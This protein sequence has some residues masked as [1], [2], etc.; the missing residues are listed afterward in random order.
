MKCIFRKFRNRAFAV[1]LALSSAFAQQT[2]VTIRVDASKPIGLLKHLND[3]D[4]GP[5]CEHGIIDLSGYYKQ[6]DVRNVRLHDAPW[7]YADVLDVDYIFPD[8]NADPDRPE[9]YRFAASDFYIAS[10]TRLNINLIYRIGYSAQGKSPTPHL[11]LPGSPEKWAD[12]AAH[13]VRHY[14][15][16][17]ANGPHA[18]IRSWEIWNEPDN[19]E[20]WSGTP[21][22]YFQLYE[23]TAKAVKAVDPSLRVGGPAIAGKLDFLEGF[24][25]YA[26]QRNLPVD[27]VS[28]HIYTQNPGDVVARAHKVREIA[29][30]LGFPH[31]ES[32]LDEWNYG[33]DDWGP[34]FKDAAATRKYFGDM[35]GAT[36]A[37]FDAAVLIALQDAPLDIATLYTGTTA[38]W[39]LFTPSGTP[40]KNF[41]ALLAFTELLKSPN[42]LAVTSSDAAIYAAAGIS[43]DGETMRILISNPTSASHPLHLNLDHF[44]W[45]D[46]AMMQEQLVD[47]SS[48]L[49]NIGSASPIGRDLQRE[50]PA[51]SVLLLTITKTAK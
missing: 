48:D 8:W 51:H 21:E 27:F 37:A 47:S 23:V 3:V 42:R 7:S 26:Q 49:G 14:N 12:V 30:R 10:L 29:D 34:L 33:P 40:Q 36:G 39:G 41:Y 43:S 5:L 45:R 35:N 22:Q 15:Q 46:H 17:W 25:R 32:I 19:A 28:W 31:A 38:V 50:L 1:A 24:L 16:G 9:S 20:F 4:N 13:I 44:S 6:L 2:P 11:F 18:N